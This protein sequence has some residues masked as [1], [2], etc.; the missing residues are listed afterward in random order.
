MR[1]LKFIRPFRRAQVSIVKIYVDVKHIESAERW[2]GILLKEYILEIDWHSNARRFHI[3]L[4]T[5]KIK[6]NN[7]ISEKF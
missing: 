4:S 2:W 6:S 3:A 7:G 1:L 5:V